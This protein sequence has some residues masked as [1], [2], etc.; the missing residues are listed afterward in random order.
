MRT[1]SPRFLKQESV[2]QI[3]LFPLE[4]L[5]VEKYSE[6]PPLGRF[7]IEGKKGTTGAGLVLEVQ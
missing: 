2:G 4:P 3:V 1:E 6:S 5:C 7:V